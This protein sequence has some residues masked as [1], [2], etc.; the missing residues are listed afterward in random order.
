MK[1][2]DLE[3][4]TEQ[5]ERLNEPEKEMTF[6]PNISGD[7]IKTKQRFKNRD[8]NLETADLLKILEIVNKNSLLFFPADGNFG[9]QPNYLVAKKDPGKIKTLL[10]FAD[11]QLPKEY[12]F[13]NLSEYFNVKGTD[14]EI[15]EISSYYY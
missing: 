1:K 4:L 15:R 2:Q 10:K 12:N 13:Q 5:H 14:I 3:F 7:P 9:F 8:E 11:S 6:T